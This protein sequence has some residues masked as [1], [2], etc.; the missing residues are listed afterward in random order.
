[1]GFL[2]DAGM[3]WLGFCLFLCLLFSREEGKEDTSD[4]I[5]YLVFFPLSANSHSVAPGFN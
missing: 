5:T 4:T 2:F 1:M 3:V